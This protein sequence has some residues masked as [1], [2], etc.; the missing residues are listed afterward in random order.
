MKVLNSIVTGGLISYIYSV[1]VLL[2]NLLTVSKG[3]VEVGVA[4]VTS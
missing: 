2:Y 1:A 4:M 3:P